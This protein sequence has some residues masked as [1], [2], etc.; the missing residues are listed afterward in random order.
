MVNAHG[1][2][3]AYDTR[4]ELKELTQHRTVSSLPF[5][6]RYRLID[7]TL[8]NLVNAGITS[9]GVV[10]R[11][12]YRS[13]LDHLGAGRDWDMNRKNGGLMVLPPYC[14]GQSM[15]GAAFRGRL[16][17][18]VGISYYIGAIR[19]KYVVIADGDL[20]SNVDLEDVI[21]HHQKSGADITVVCTRSPM[22]DPK[23]VYLKTDDAGRAVNIRVGGEAE[24]YL[25]S[26]N[27][28]VLE[29]EL[30][31]KIVKVADEQGQYDWVRD[32]LQH[33]LDSV[34]VGTYVSD[35]YCARM[36][37]VTDYFKRNMDLLRPEVRESLFTPKRAIRTKVRDENS[38][39]YSPDSHAKNSLIADGCYIEGTVE[40]CVLF[41]GVRIDKGAD[42]K[43][44]ILM[45]GT[46]V[47]AG[48]KLRHVIADKDVIISESR[49]LIGHNA[50]PIAIA[51]GSRV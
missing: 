27:I 47:R 34:Y 11:D 40:H 2:V 18:L 15:G 44:S 1:I 36:L 13:L 6:G 35:G 3:L 24:D 37:R 31:K 14:Y 48:A 28:F 49:E 17:A 32:V 25:E 45:Q 7:F 9:A 30:L 19:Q 41:R 5:G 50:Y 23:P 29:T 22:D 42:V 33:Q 26:M 12:N 8:S 20:V 21:E 38:T 4:P 43:D 10:V 16:D 39:Y 46:H 51:K